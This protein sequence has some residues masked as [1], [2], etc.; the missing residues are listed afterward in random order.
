[1][2]YDLKLLENFN[3]FEFNVKIKG[4]NLPFKKEICITNALSSKKFFSC[5]LRKV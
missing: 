1:M 4:C 5:F 3:L 2:A